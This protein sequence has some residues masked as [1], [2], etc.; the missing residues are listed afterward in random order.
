MYNCYDC[1]KEIKEV[2]KE[3]VE[4][5]FLV[6]KVNDEKINIIK[7]NECYSKNPALTNFQ[8]CEVYS[9]I[10]GYIRP[11]HQWNTGK[12]EE[13]KDRKEYDV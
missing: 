10:V 8:K 7:C 4:A 3:L 9:R 12:Q 5:Q 6:Y 2:N 13:Y 11:V 1:N